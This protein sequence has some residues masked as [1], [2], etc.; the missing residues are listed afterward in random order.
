M[1]LKKNLIMG[2]KKFLKFGDEGFTLIELLVV[3]AIIVILTGIVLV[4]MMGAR[5]VS[6]DAR[7]K[8]DLEEIRNQLEICRTDDGKYPSGSLD[9]GD[10]FTCGTAPSSYSYTLPDDPSTYRYHYQWITDST[11]CLCAYIEN[12]PPGLNNCSTYCNGGGGYCVDD[13]NYETTEP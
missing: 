3:V 12:N 8:A 9:S 5:R 2:F 10:S 7:R 4:S 6:R 11:Y 1:K 13:C